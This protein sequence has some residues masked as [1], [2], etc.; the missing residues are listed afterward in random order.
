MEIQARQARKGNQ[1]HYY[2]YCS[3]ACANRE[4]DPEVAYQPLSPASRLLLTPAFEGHNCRVCRKR[5]TGHSPAP[6]TTSK[7]PIAP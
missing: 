4:Q 3:L 5:L 1:T 7:I 2:L 6:V